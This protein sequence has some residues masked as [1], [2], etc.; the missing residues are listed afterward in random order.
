MNAARTAL[1]AVTL[2][3][4]VAATRVL[5]Q[6]PL[7]ST[8]N[9]VS[10]TINRS[11]QHWHFDGDVSTVNPGNHS[12]TI[13]ADSIP[14]AYGGKT[15]LPYTARDSSELAKFHVG[16]RVNGDLVVRNNRSFVE[17]LKL[18][19]TPRPGTAMKKGPDVGMQKSSGG[20]MKKE[21]MAARGVD[22]KAAYDKNC[23]SCH[24]VKGMPPAALSKQLKI[25]KWD[26]AYLAARSDDS[27]VRV[28][29]QG[30]KVMKGF[31]G[32]M[33]PQQMEAVAKYIREMV[34]KP[35]S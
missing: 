25:P 24:G 19:S 9:H 1:T 7:D 8:K 17:N 32:K 28:M 21:T 22:G 16:D 33:T 2:M 27:L 23:K 13:N 5:A 11:V 14:Q 34:G 29:K 18:G 15:T 10:D 30:G 35:A 4:A 31:E 12:L 3:V 26:A 6:D 20:G